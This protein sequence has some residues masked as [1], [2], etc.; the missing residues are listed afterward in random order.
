MNIIVCLDDKN[1]MLFGGRRQSMDRI[2]RQETLALAAPQPLWMNSYT[3]RQ[4]AEDDCEIQEDEA[5]LDNAPAD[6]WCF[7]ENS[8]LLPYLSK[9]EKVAVYRWNR[10]YPSDLRLDLETLLR[11]RHM[12][13]RR[14]FPG[15][16]HERITEE[17]YQF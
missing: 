4:F 17:V 14:E 3:A 5:F 16:S 10:L 13:S 1:G 7:V 2:L 8:A 6:A 9:I 15:S 11:G 12:I